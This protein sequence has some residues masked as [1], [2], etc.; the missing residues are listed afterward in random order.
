MNDEILTRKFCVESAESIRVNSTTLYNRL[1][2]S[3][4]PDAIIAVMDR[5]QKTLD[6]IREKLPE[7]STFEATMTSTYRRGER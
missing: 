4:D 7:P 6:L 3:P 1:T 2:H 5:L